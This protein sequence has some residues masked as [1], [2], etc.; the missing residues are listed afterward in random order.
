[1]TYTTNQ[2]SSL[3]IRSVAGLSSLSKFQTRL[4]P[5]L[6]DY[7]LLTVHY[8]TL[9]ARPSALK[10]SAIG[11]STLGNGW[12]Y[13]FLILAAFYYSGVKALPII[14]IGAVNA[15]V[16]H[17]IYPV[18]KKKFARR[19]PFHIDVRLPSL[20]KT[21]DDHSFPSGH[22]MTLTGVLT[23]IVLAWP[24]ATFSAIVLVLSMGWSRIA[25]AHH[26]PSDVIAGFLLGLLIA[27]P[28]SHWGF[29]FV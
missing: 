16:L 23:P 29:M 26:F 22:A 4:L 3:S 12:I 10:Y 9:T 15:L 20:L 1:M 21:L 8:F 24:S 13:I 28:L 7:E 2:T 14:L 25:T 27:Y 6:A 11:I 5:R 17:C 19:R 18:L